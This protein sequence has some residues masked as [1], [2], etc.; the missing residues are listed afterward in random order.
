MQ[1]SHVVLAFCTPQHLG[2]RWQGHVGVG[3]KIWKQERKVRGSFEGKRDLKKKEETRKR[4]S[5]KERRQRG[6][7]KRERKKGG[8][9]GRKGKKGREKGRG[10]KGRKGGES[11]G[12][13]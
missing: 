6:E 2:A 4:V 3:G 13:G 11:G 1:M 8:R 7:R 9:R 10:E 12:R 5:G